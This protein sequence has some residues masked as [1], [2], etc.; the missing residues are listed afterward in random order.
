MI[1]RWRVPLV[2]TAAL[3]LAQLLPVLPLSDVV[4][5]LAPRDV[6]LSWPI[7]HVLLAPFTLL[8]DWLNGANRAELKGFGLWLLVGYALARLLAAP[9]SFRLKTEVTTAACC[10]LACSLFVWWGARWNRPIP[11]LVAADSSL[12]IFDV[13]SHTSASHDGRPGFGSAENARWHGRAGFDAAFI[14][15][16][17]VVG[18]ARQWRVDAPGR[19]PRL[20][21]GE[22][23]SLFGLHVVALGVS[24][25]IDPAPWSHTFDSTLRLLE[26]PN[27]PVGERPYFIASLPEFWEHHWGA[28]IGRLVDAGVRGFEVMTTSPK[29]MDFPESGRATLIARAQGEHLAL[30]GAT[31]MHGLGNTAEV[32]NVTRL[33]GWRTMS[34]S[35]LTR[36]LIERFTAAPDSVRVVA[37]TRWSSEARFAQPFAAPMGVV[38]ALRASSRAHAVSLLVWIWG[39]ALLR[40]RRRRASAAA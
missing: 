12:L 34:D 3:V 10:L 22:E 20:L 38:G 1:A 5:G 39:I 23:L 40:T 32:W 30:F 28:D 26:S 31:D 4:H 37:L 9:V 29:A 36:A 14:T 16:H 6:R 24:R 15:D 8:A 17:N 2:L 35:A 13:H 25:R 18:A 33:V 19:A 7:T 21:D 27:D 11:R